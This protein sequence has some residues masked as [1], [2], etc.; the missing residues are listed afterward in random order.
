[1]KSQALK[2]YSGG[3]KARWRRYGYPAFWKMPAIA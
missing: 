2:N 3:Q 1:M